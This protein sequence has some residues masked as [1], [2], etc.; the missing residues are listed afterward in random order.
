MWHDI[1]LWFWFGNAVVLFIHWFY[2]Q[3]IDKTLNINSSNLSVDFFY[4][5]YITNHII[6]EK[7]KLTVFLFF[8]SNYCD[9]FFFYFLPYWL[10]S[11]YFIKRSSLPGKKYMA[12]ERLVMHANVFL[13]LYLKSNTPYFQW[14]NM[15]EFDRC[16]LQ[17]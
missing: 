7:K 11:I 6:R 2:I 17:Y 5:S 8:L 14:K 1:W 9:C 13:F 3:H 4:N 12:V 15:N 10:G 16:A